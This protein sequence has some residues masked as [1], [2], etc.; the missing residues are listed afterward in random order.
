MQILITGYT[1]FI[2]TN[3][4]RSVK[5]HVVNGLDIV[6]NNTVQ[7]HFYW[8]DINK[9]NKADCIIH[10]AGKVHDTKN[11]TDEQS[12]FDINTGLTKTIFDHFL[13]SNASKF[14]FFSSVKAVADTVEDSE[15]TEETKPNPQTP[16]GRSKLEAEQYILN[17]SLPK[18]KQVYILRPS[19]IHGPGNKGNLNLLFKIV[20]KGI[21]WPL[22]AFKNRRSFTSI[23][24]LNF[25]IKE[26]IEKDIEPGVYN[27]SDDN[28][29]STNEI[30]ELIAAS[31]N[32]NPKILK[33]PVGLIKLA[34]KIGDII[35]LPLNSERLK[36]LTESYVVSN[37]KLKK[38][39]NINK[40]PISATEGMEK[41]LASFKSVRL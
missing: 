29:L 22:G 7:Q 37:K 18:G 23:D 41:T 15:L 10:L 21:P 27:V 16:Y 2:G 17:Q 6:K 35:H 20:S 13:K 19:M 14:I 9:C 38:A 8:E 26:I 32:G 4:I 40:M 12:Y 1:G 3:L 24:N 11:T 34:A 28:T 39:L 36:K 5:N 31:Q 30:I 33:L 25:I